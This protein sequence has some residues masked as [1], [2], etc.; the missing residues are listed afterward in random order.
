MFPLSYYLLIP[1]HF[2]PLK[3][4]LLDH[5]VFKQVLGIPRTPSYVFCLSC[6]T[7]V[8]LSPSCILS[9]VYEFI[10]RLV[11]LPLRVAV[12]R[13]SYKHEEASS[14]PSALFPS[15]AVQILGRGPFLRNDPLSPRSPRTNQ[16][17]QFTIVLSHETSILAVTSDVTF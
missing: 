3:G 12:C 7:F 6:L 9:A 5:L 16:R 4:D 14:L 8:P 17:L 13:A 11:P 10:T 1:S 15:V 2:H